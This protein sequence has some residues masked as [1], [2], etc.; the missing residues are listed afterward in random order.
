MLWE[1]PVK[2]SSREIKIETL[3]CC[4]N[5]PS[6]KLLSW[7]LQCFAHVQSKN[8]VAESAVSRVILMKSVI[9]QSVPECTYCLKSKI[10]SL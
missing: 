8:K 2:K 7:L 6:F 1:I 9:T 5:Y 10:Y 4:L 3:L